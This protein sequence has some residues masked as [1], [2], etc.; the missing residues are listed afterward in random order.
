[1]ATT[2]KSAPKAAPKSAPKA[3]PKKS[4]PVAQK[5][6]RDLV[7]EARQNKLYRLPSGGGIWYKLKQTNITVF[8]EETGLVR[9]LRYSPNENSVFADEQGE[10]IIRE[11]II[12]R[13]KELYVPYNKPNLMKY[14]D[15]HPDNFANGGN[16][17]ELVNNEAK[18]EVEI[19]QEFAMVDAVGMVRDKSI[20]ELLPVALYLGISVNQ[21]NMEIKRELLQEAKSNPVRF[22]KMFDNPQVQTRSTIMNAVDFQILRA[23]ADGLKWYDSG[24]LIVSTPAGQ[25][26]LDVATRFCLTER[27]ATV[28]EEIERQLSKI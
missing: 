17:F 20:D 11:Q 15:L 10:N 6:K 2:A 24:K 1:M 16:R 4:A 9:Q 18:A 13:N 14:L 5:V 19:E 8:D 7:E 23:D 12:F 27:G 28:F 3:A 26:T 21:K 25:E 22:I